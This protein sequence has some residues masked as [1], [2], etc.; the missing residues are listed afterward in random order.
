MSA[1]PSPFGPPIDP[2]HE[3]Y[4]ARM[5]NS[6]HCEAAKDLLL[7]MRATG[8]RCDTLTVGKDGVSITGVQD[9]Y[10][11]KQPA[12]PVAPSPSSDDDSRLYDE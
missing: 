2:I 7:F 8:I 3:G 6:T 10:P 1:P 11:R 4:R 9:D 5:K 12:R